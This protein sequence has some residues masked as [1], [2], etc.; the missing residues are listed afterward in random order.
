MSF[1]G[2]FMG[3]QPNNMYPGMPNYY[4]PAPQPQ[5]PNYYPG[6]TKALMNEYQQP[7]LKGRLVSSMEEAK[8]SQIDY[9][10]SLF[11]FP[12]IANN[13][14]YTRKF[15]QDG[16]VSFNIYEPFQMDMPQRGA[17]ATTVN[18]NGS[19]QPDIDYITKADFDKAISELKESFEN[20]ILELMSSIEGNKNGS[21]ADDVVSLV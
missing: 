21:K 16:T 10:G 7:Y 8:A 9:D 5:Q 18:N 6:S 17:V 12:D 11:I 15:N 13:Q 19:S 3:N 20:N 1:S 4:M 2:G 14:I